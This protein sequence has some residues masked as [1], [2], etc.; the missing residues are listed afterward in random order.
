M[1]DIAFLKITFTENVSLSLLRLYA[2]LLLY[3]WQLANFS[4]INTPLN[5][6]QIF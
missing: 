3:M 1:N 2:L 4:N 6:V 5:N